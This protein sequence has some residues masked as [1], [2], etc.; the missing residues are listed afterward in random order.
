MVRE[1]GTVVETRWER[2]DGLRVRCLAAGS[3]ELSPTLLLH[4]GGFEPPIFPTGTPSSPYLACAPYSLS[5]GRDTEGATNRT[6][7]TTLPTTHASSS[8]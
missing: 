5:T 4:G 8:V 1:V 6:S 2:V 3:G 7:G